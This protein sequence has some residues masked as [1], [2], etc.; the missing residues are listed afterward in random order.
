MKRYTPVLYLLFGI[1]VM[2]VSCKK[3]AVSP[4]TEYLQNTKIKADTSAITTTVKDT[5]TVDFGDIVVR[6]EQSSTCYPGREIFS[7]KAT[8]TTLPPGVF[9]YWAF[10]DGNTATGASV[11]Y[12]YQAASSFVVNLMVVADVNTVLTKLSFPIKAKGQQTRPVA[13]FTVKSDFPDNI[14][15]LT[16]NTSSSVNHGDISYYKWEWGDGSSTLTSV[17][18]IRHEFPRN[19][20]DITY[21]V[22]LTITTNT[23]CAADTTIAVTIPAA[24]P[25]KGGFRADALNACT[26]ESIVFTAEAENV[27]GGSVYEWDFSDGKGV[28][29]GNPVTY[30]YKYPNDYDVIMS[31]RLN[32]RLIYRTNKMVNAKGE[33]PKPTAAFEQTMVWQ[34]STTAHWLF[35]SRSTIPTG[36]IDSYQWSFGNG[37]T[38]NDY[39]SSVETNYQK[40]STA[41]SY[42]VQLVV[43]G[44]GC[45]DTTSKVITIPAQ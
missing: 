22:K 23:G 1:L 14:N 9:Y 44:N 39:Y 42:K 25:I 45:A 10:G 35:N 3:E 43:T 40:E 31:V 20:A 29:T 33:N 12:S 13:G 19:V 11:S 37:N 8:G 34:N 28:V 15:Y 41:K 5:T 30:K 6:Y 18:L 4:I 2:S 38:S 36:S 26:N 21:P 17:G 24:Y 16:F 7:F 32:G 27:P